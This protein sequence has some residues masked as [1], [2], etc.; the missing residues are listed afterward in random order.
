MLPGLRCAD[1][2]VGFFFLLTLPLSHLLCCRLSDCS[3]ALLGCFLT[4]ASTS[5]RG[6]AACRAGTAW[7]I[8]CTEELGMAGWRVGTFGNAGGAA[9]GRQHKV[10]KCPGWHPWLPAGLLQ[11]VSKI[12]ELEMRLRLVLCPVQRMHCSS[13]GWVTADTRGVRKHEQG[14][15]PLLVVVLAGHLQSLKSDFSQEK[16]VTLSA[17]L[18]FL[19]R[20][21]NQS[22]ERCF[23]SQNH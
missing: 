4:R 17:L 21:R 16:S 23:S 13:L 7:S 5:V 8:L 18:L 11:C 9:T 20:A 10:C 12:T 6:W 14:Q 1:L 19:F 2:S 15:F 22:P 3:P